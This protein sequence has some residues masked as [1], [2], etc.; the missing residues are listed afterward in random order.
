MPDS[1]LCG[2]FFPLPEFAE[3]RELTR[4]NLAEVAR[5]YPDIEFLMENDFPC[6][7]A[8]NLFADCASLLDC[9]MCLDTSHLWASAFIFDRGF[10]TE[11]ADFLQTGRV[12]MV[13]LHASNFTAVTPKPLWGDGH[14]PLTTPNEMGLPELVAR[15][16]T[17]GV[18]HFVLEIRKS[19]AADIECFVAMWNGGGERL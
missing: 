16:R 4:K 19:S 1:R 15:C 2:N 10:M 12:R 13:H 3:R 6:Y 14:L 11:T 8:A 17:A 5:R 9:H 7:G 18:N